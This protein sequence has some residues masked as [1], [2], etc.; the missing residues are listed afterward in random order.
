M[1]LLRTLL[2]DQFTAAR[3]EISS[4]V[5]E[6]GDLSVSSVSVAQLLGGLR[7]VNCLVCDTS[8]VDPQRGLSIRGIPV[9]ALSDRHPEEVFW[10]LLTGQLPD[11]SQLEALR[12]ELQERRRI[13]VCVPEMLAAMPDGSHPMV[14]FSA[15]LLAMQGQSHFSQSR[16]RTP[17]DELWKLA[18]EDA[19]DIFSRLPLVAAAVYQ[20]CYGSGDVIQGQL[21]GWTEDFASRL[22]GH[23]DGD[24]RELLKRY[25]VVQSDHENGNVCALSAHITGSTHADLYYAVSSGANG[26]AGH[27]HGLAAQDFIRFLLAI[28]EQLGAEASYGGVRALLEQRLREGRVLPGFGHAVLRAPDPRFGVLHRL[29]AERYGSDP[30][31]R[32]AEHVYGAGTELLT[33]HPRVRNPHPNVDAITGLVLRLG[34]IRHDQFYTVLFA[35]SLA[36]GILAQNVIS[37]GIGSPIVRPRSVS[38]AQLHAELAAH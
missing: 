4:L 1:K 38:L 2:Q 34:G 9:A 29:A 24:F 13:P 10:L 12:D 26:L 20:R 31:F 33:A 14:M 30:L 15:S 32:L 17:R 37:R 7:G 16:E 21:R 23:D 6:H 35:C 22:L 25:V 11:E 28:Q 3:R 18:L 19:L 8:S 27:I 36:I 5:T